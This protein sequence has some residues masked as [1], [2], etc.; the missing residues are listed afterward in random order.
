MPLVLLLL[1]LLLFLLLLLSSSSSLRKCGL[2]AVC[3]L[4]LIFDYLVNCYCAPCDSISLS[5]ILQLV[6]WLDI[7]P[8]KFLTGDLSGSGRDNFLLILWPCRY[9]YNADVME[10]HTSL[11][12][13]C[14]GDIFNHRVFPLCTP[15]LETFPVTAVIGFFRNCQK[16]TRWH[17]IQWE[18]IWGF[19]MFLD[20]VCKQVIRC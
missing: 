4:P 18:R 6:H 13:L 7:H 9:K 8:G 5:Q 20:R 17:F 11:C 10:V 3:L 19:K 2:T 14:A 16:M 15:H 12:Q 1:V